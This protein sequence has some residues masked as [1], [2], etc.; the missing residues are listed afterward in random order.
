MTTSP[1]ARVPEAETA[2]NSDGFGRRGSFEVLSTAS[3]GFCRGDNFADIMSNDEG[4]RSHSPGRLPAADSN[5][6]A[7]SALDLCATDISNQA[8]F[9]VLTVTGA[10]ALPFWPGMARLKSCPDTKQEDSFRILQSFIHGVRFVFPDRPD[11][12]R[13]HVHFQGGNTLC[14]GW[15]FDS[16][17]VV[18]LRLYHDRR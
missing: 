4:K 17:S 1:N 7:L 15:A 3:G 5:S 9:G 10:K 16:R 13:L 12:E 14:S 2:R 18:D 8:S 6:W 11:A